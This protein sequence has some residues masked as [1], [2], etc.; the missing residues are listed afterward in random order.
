VLC[1]WL[2]LFTAGL[3]GGDGSR[4]G[5]A[6]FVESVRPECEAIQSTYPP[7]LDVLP[8]GRAVVATE[9]T[10]DILP[11]ELGGSRPAYVGVT[12]LPGLP[13]DSDG[14]G[15]DDYLRSLELGLPGTPRFSR[16]R[17]V[18]NDLVLVSAS[19]YEEVLAYDPITSALTTIRVTNPPTSGD[20]HPDDHPLLP[21]AGE[22]A[23][24][25]AIATRVCVRPPP[26]AETSTGGVIAPGCDPA[27]PSFWTSF[28]ADAAVVDGVLVA[29]TS[30]LAS[31]QNGEF[32]PGTALLFSFDDSGASPALAPLVDAPVVF[33]SEFN[34]TSVTPWTTS[35]GRTLALI[36]STGAIQLTSGPA[37]VASDASIDVLDVASRRISATIPM[38]PAALGYAGL[39]I[40]A[41]SGLAIAGSPTMKRIYAVDLAVLDDESIY[42]ASGPPVVLDGSDPAH[43]DA[44]IF[45]GDAP[46]VIPRRP[47]GA[48]P[49]I[50]DGWTNVLVGPDRDG[51]PDRRDLYVNDRCDGTLTIVD[52]DLTDAIELPLS[53]GRFTVDRQLPIAA[54]KKDENVGRDQEPDR[55]VLGP[56]GATPG[57]DGPALYYL[58]DVPKALF[59]AL[60]IPD[61]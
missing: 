46:F 18:R 38:G 31:S 15:D 49:A 3:C 13:A 28:T 23:D 45:S 59:C 25:T 7:G 21:P 60:E 42:T 27:V 12:S 57:A 47:D 50:C 24:R 32:R 41:A 6:V 2:P 40:D 52:I 9:G 8:N 1:A 58:I 20:H 48:D 44:R 11:F 16:L 10:K 5:G 55:M 22:T 56:A 34:P 30:N 19:G 33:S 36:G 4:G 39:A 53:P 26:G 51:D 35:T 17:A 29:V 61:F 37:S 54:A 14:D 43:P